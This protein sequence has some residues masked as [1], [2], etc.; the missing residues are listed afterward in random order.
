M[1]RSK[2]C[3]QNKIYKISCNTNKLNIEG[4]Q[5]PKHTLDA[6][7][8]KTIWK[9]QQSFSKISFNKQILKFIYQTPVAPAF[10]S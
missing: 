10:P 5:F 2:P 7:D 8:K 3:T 9:T 4:I 1:F 6:D